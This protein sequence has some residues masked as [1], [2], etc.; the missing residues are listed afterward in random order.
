M[1]AVYDLIEEVFFGADDSIFDK[2]FL[3]KFGIRKKELKKKLWEKFENPETLKKIAKYAEENELEEVFYEQAC[4]VIFCD[5][6]LHPEERRFLDAFA[7]MLDLL[8]FD[9][10]RIETAYLKEVQSQ[11]SKNAHN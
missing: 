6:E 4:A 3:E 8:K 9:K 7:Q 10:Q 5:N 1:E 11:S 2:A